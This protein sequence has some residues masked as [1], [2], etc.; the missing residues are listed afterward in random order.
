MFTRDDVE[1]SAETPIFLS[2]TQTAA[3]TGLALSSVFELLRHGELASVR[4]GKRRL[5]SRRS[6]EAWAT[7]KLAEAGHSGGEGAA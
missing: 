7:A 2:P 5:I 4:H 6:I 3:I 1:R